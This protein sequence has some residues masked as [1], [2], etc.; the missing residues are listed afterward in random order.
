VS[1]A[2]DLLEQARH[3]ARRERGRPRQAS[4]RRAI[5]AAYYSLFHLFLEE[6]ALQAVPGSLSSWRPVSA[7][8][9]NHG[10]LKKVAVWFVSAALP[11]PL[12][13]NSPLSTD[14]RQVARFVGQ[15]QQM[16]HQ[17]DYDTT[18]RFTRQDVLLLVR[19]TEQS[20]AAWER[21]RN[22]EEARAFLLLL[23]ITDRWKR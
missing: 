18:A 17:A 16:R 22:T 5:S 6:A 3:L 12:T 21:V 10:D 4:L 23:L 14:I 7:R 20:F 8:A 1:L 13:L 9:I 2:R 19:D 11:A 15:L